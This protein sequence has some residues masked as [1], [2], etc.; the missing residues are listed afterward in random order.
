VESNRKAT[1]L[2]FGPAHIW[3]LAVDQS[4]GFTFGVFICDT[5]PQ[6][7]HTQHQPSTNQSAAITSPP[8][9]TPTIT[10]PPTP[11]WCN[12][13]NF[14]IGKIAQ[15]KA[16]HRGHLPSVP[17]STTGKEKQTKART[18]Q[19]QEEEEKMYQAKNGTQTPDRGFR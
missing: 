17:T 2:S 10:M 14:W 1:K 15:P 3:L 13:N 6:T 9:L 11:S 19:N 5:R 16:S 7:L 4:F 8:T 12:A 18:W